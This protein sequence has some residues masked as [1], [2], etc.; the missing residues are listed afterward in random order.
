MVKPF[1]LRRCNIVNMIAP[2]GKVFCLK[3]L[4]RYLA[5]GVIIFGSSACSIAQQKNA[6]F[7]ATPSLQTTP[8]FSITPLSSCK[9]TLDDG[10]SPSYTP[11][12]PERA[13]VGK[14][15]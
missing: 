8:T 6:T 14:G 2:D 11:D 9:P 7:E 13:A 5:L 10:V 15:H 3:K 12:S 1:H 4:S